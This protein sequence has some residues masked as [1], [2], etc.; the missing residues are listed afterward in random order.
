MGL[1]TDTIW[2]MIPNAGQNVAYTATVGKLTNRLPEG[3]RAV[4]VYVTSAA[5]VMVGGSVAVASATGTAGNGFLLPAA[6]WQVLDAQAGDWVSAVRLSGNG[7][8]Y[9]CPL[10]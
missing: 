8:L 5:F 2:R 10:F 7:T 1:R 4:A 3:T 9:A 6:G